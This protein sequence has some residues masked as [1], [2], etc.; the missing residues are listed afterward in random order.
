M[1]QTYPTTVSLGLVLC[2]YIFANMSQ[3]HQRDRVLPGADVG[4]EESF[5]FSY[6]W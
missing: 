4:G 6:A 3:G 1:H 2:K 5:R